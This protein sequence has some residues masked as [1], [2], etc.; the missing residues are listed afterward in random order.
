MFRERKIIRLAFNIMF[1]LYSISLLCF[2][3]YFIFINKWDDFN[4]NILFVCIFISSILAIVYDVIN[5]KRIQKTNVIFS[6]LCLLIILYLIIS[7]S[8]I[9]VV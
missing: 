7:F 6:F 1:Y 4:L 5:D 2:C 8:P 3:A 9:N